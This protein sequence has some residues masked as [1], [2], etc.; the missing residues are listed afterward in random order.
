[1][2]G[3]EAA[4]DAVARQLG[5]QAKEASTAAT[6]RSLLVFCCRGLS[7]VYLANDGRGAFFVRQCFDQE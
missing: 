6:E 5:R 3:E 2:D 7:A 4:E 1:V